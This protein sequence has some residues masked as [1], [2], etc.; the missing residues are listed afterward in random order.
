MFLILQLYTP[1]SGLVEEVRTLQTED[2]SFDVTIERIKRLLD[3]MPADRST[4]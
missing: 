2:L 3:N 4:D 1:G